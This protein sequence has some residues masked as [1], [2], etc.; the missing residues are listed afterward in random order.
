MTIE[1]YPRWDAIRM[2]ELVKNKQISPSELLKEA[3]ERIERINPKINAIIYPLFEEAKKGISS[4]SKGPL[5]GVPFLLKDLLSHL[6]GTPLSSGSKLFQGFISP[7]DSEVVKRYKKAGLVIL[8]KTNT[9]ELGLMGTTEPDLFG[10]TR[11]PW[12]LNH[13][14]GGSSGGSAAAVASRMVPVAGG[15]DGGGS[16]RIPASCCGVFG[17]KPSR[18][19]VPHG[20]EFG[21][22]WEGAVEE[23]VVSLS[24]RDSAL[25]LDLISGPDKGAMYWL[26]Q[27]KDPFISYTQ[28]KP[29]SLKIGMCTTS[30]VGGRVDIECKNA[31]EET[32]KLLEEM[33]HHVEEIAL[34]YDGYLMADCYFTLY[35]GQVRAL[36]LHAKEQTGIEV[37]KELMEI[38]TWML[39]IL[40]KKIDAG[41]YACSLLKWNK[42]ARDMA[43]FHERFHLLLTP[44]IATPP[45]RLGELRSSG[46]EKAL[47]TLLRRLNLGL[48]L[49][50]A[51]VKKLSLKR[52]EIMPFTQIANLTGQPAMS[53]PL[54]WTRENLPCGVQFIAPLGEEKLLFSLAAELERARPWRDKLPPVCDP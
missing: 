49:N 3:I 45:P 22:I 11:N 38:E 52:F 18:G 10:P 39:N 12:N 13:I 8:G 35:F 43:K 6:K 16:L 7:F 5:L 53:V 54:H 34:P 28:K 48:F 51:V 15:G 31:V 20:P 25:I 17:L 32:A 26:P 46:V 2:A 27:E 14:P 41:A 4:L 33:G 1:E 19:R 9:P 23:H 30:P 40:G 44:T 24:V 21:E 29:P 50:P 37:K 47:L 42:L 36:L